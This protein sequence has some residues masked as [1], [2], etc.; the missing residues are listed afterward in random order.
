[1]KGYV[2]SKRGRYY[3]VIYE[4]LDPV[5]GRERRSWHPA[6]TDRAEAERLA[7]RLADERNGRNDEVRSLT[8]GA[9]LTR[10]WLPG[11]KLN[12]AHE[13]LPQL[14]ATRPSATSSPPS[15]APGLRALRPEHLETLYDRMLHPTDG[16]R[17]LAPKTVYEVHLIIR[18][19]LDRR[20]PPRARHPQRRRSSPT[21]R[22][23]GRSPR[24]NSRPGP[25]SSSR[26]SCG[27]PPGTACSPPSGSSAMTGMRRSELLGL[28]W[29]DI[30]FDKAA[31][32]INRGLVAVGYELHESRGKTDNSRRSHRP[33][34]HHHRGPA[35]PGGR[36]SPPSTTPI[37]IE[38][39]GWVFTSTEGRPVHPA[40]HHPDLRA[41]RAPRRRPGHPPPRPAPHPRHAAHQGRRPRQGRQRA[42]RPRQHRLHHR[43]L[44]AR[45][46]RHA[47]RRRP[48]LR[49]PRRP[50]RTPGP[51]TRRLKTRKNDRPEPGRTP[52]R[53]R[54]PR[55]LTWAFSLQLVA[56][57]GFE[58]T[59][60]GL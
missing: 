60:F 8:F 10:R 9:Y 40:R 5:T 58:P 55:S 39:P 32:G 27:P 7:D 49:S 48:H 29:P 3:A 50:R 31:I 1:M 22:G 23:C 30:D 21:H 54:R 19:A 52:P 26:R 45:P 20:R 17:P 28:R 16:S 51:K 41:D 57:V 46:P 43:D 24:S 37:G 59:T 34:P 38:D 13:H 6:G 15:A 2:T 25:P 44:P 42:T 4:G 36:C 11:K 35:R 18:G 33:R 12:L 53:R 56:G 47:G 14:R